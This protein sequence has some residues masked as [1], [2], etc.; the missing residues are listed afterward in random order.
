MIS[1]YIF[2]LV[3]IYIYLYLFTYYILY[4]CKVKEVPRAKMMIVNGCMITLSYLYL[5][6]ELVELQG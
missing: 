4:L 5:N 1:V 3:C 6:P 2:I